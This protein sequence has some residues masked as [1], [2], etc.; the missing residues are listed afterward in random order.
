MFFFH[1]IKGLM[2]MIHQDPGWLCPRLKKTLN[3]Y[4]LKC[5]WSKRMGKTLPAPVF[6][7]RGQE[8]RRSIMMA[9][10]LTE[11]GIYNVF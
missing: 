5:Q 3:K 11:R 4:F 6:G 7:G 10:R 9:E 8:L 1:G 2:V